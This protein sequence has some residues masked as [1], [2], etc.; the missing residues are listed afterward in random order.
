[1]TG[2]V[3]DMLMRLRGNLPP[4]FPPQGA[5]P[6]LD[7]ILTGIATVLSNIYGV[8][9]F[10]RSQVR[11]STASGGFLDLIAWD[12]FGDLIARYSDDTDASFLARIL[13]FLLMPRITRA[14]I[15]AMLTALTG[16]KP[17]ILALWN[18]QDC[19]GWSDGVAPCIMGWDQAGAWG[20]IV[21]NQLT[22]V[23]YRPFGVLGIPPQAGWADGSP[24]YAGDTIFGP[25]GQFGLGQIETEMFPT[26]GGFDDGTGTVG[27]AVSWVSSASISGDVTD[28]LIEKFVAAWVAAGLNYTLY[29]SN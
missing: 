25:T 23:A 3:P 2:D 11:I 27:G 21:P 28:A 29:I 19:G 26:P 12:Y 7:A 15:T 17:G 1:M 18:P 9:A 22:I 14:G 13:Q 8:V 24:L 10:A 6:V 5:A 16:R 20:E 4:W